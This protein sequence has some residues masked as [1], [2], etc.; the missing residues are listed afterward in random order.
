MIDSERVKVYLERARAVG[1]RVEWM[2]QGDF[3]ARLGDFLGKVRE[4]WEREK[5]DGGPESML[6]GWDG[7]TSPP[8]ALSAAVPAEGWPP[9]LRERAESTLGSCGF[10]IVSPQKAGESFAWDRAELSAAIRGVPFCGSY[11]A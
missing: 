2:A 11:L 4:A 8:S 1:T 10:H 3:P 6:K 5:R 7:S 9:G